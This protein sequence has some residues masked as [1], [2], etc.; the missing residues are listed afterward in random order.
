MAPAEIRPGL[1]VRDTESQRAGT[2]FGIWRDN[3]RDRGHDLVSV[4]V[5]GNA[6]IFVRAENLERM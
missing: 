2:V 4:R 5:D 6:L 1:R 3:D